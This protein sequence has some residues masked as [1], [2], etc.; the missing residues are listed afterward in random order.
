MLSL[1]LSVGLSAVQL[2]SLVFDKPGFVVLRCCGLTRH[3][4]AVLVS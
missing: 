2:R 3:G 1:R 4:A